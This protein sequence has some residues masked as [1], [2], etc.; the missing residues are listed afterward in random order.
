MIKVAS[1]HT[2]RQTSDFLVPKFFGVRQGGHQR[3]PPLQ[4][5]TVNR[6]H[7]MSCQ[8]QHTNL[9]RAMTEAAS[10]L[11]FGVTSQI[12]VD[13]PN[14]AD[15]MFRQAAEKVGNKIVM[16]RKIY[17]GAPCVANTRVPVYVILQMVEDGCSHKQIL[18]AF[19]SIGKE[20]LEA[21][22][23]FSALVMER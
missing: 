22:L 7:E 1:A 16:N 12:S 20:G 13:L 17:G 4:K 2:H 21:S 14:S 10:Q 18:R 19:P 15:E 3:K 5:F 8:E 23:R 9:A 11:A 6:R